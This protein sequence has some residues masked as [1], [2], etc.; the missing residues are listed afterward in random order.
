VLAGVLS[1]Q[2]K[3]E[4]SEKREP[5]LRKLLH[6]IGL[7]GV[8]LIDDWWKRAQP[9]VVRNTLGQAVL[10]WSHGKLSKPWGASQ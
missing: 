8:F 5:Q 9:T 6:Q 2:H 1:A 3:L 7:W 4:S 10:E